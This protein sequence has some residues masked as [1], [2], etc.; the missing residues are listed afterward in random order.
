[1]MNTNLP[2]Y[3][4]DE[5]NGLAYQ[6]CGDYYL[7]LLT[8]PAC[9]DQ[10]L[11]HWAQMHRRYLKENHPVLYSELLMTGRLHEYLASVGR[12]AQ[13]RMDMLVR[14]MMATEGVTEKMKEREQLAWVGAMNSIDTRAKEIVLAEI[15]CC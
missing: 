5:R 14:Q 6:L 9:D 12:D 1:M 3:C 4:T 8:V 2:N 11:G 15:I 7:P 13:A 10:P